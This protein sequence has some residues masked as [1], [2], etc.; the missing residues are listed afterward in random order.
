MA[1]FKLLYTF[2][3]LFF[4]TSVLLNAQEE[5]TAASLYNDA[6]AKLK[7]KDYKAAYPLIQQSLEKA[8]P[9]NETDAKVIGL[10]KKN[11]A[12]AT[13]RLGSAARKA[14]DYDK[15]LEYFAQGIEW[16]P[17]NYTNVVGKAQA[18]EGKGEL[19]E[20]LPVYIEAAKLSKEAGKDPKA[21]Y[22]KAANFVAKAY[23][24]KN[25][26][27][28]IALADAHNELVEDAPHSV[29]YYL[30][31]SLLEKGDAAKG[32]AELD[33]AIE[34]AGADAK[35]LGKYHFKKGQCHEKLGQKTEA[36]EAY[37]KVNDPKYKEAA[38]YQIT[39]LKSK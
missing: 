14:K 12:V 25:Y 35:E 31:A 13:Y 1:K 2:L 18:L 10:A 16:N 36:I 11:G 7:E 23:A 26:D 27:E 8:D 5:V 39:Q 6:L 15:A 33:K 34:K 21:F 24:K 3:L 17:T 29:Y 32:V 19:A 30:G 28:A 37:G 38:D 4:G 22:K 20:A 9:E